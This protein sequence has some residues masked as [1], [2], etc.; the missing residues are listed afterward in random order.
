MNI[1]LVSH[2]FSVTGA[3]NSLLRQA[4][5]FR[6][7]GHN[8]DVWALDSGD[9]KARYIEAGFNPVIVKNS[10]EA[11]KELYDTTNKKYDFVLCNTIIA[12]KAVEVLQQQKIPMV[13]FIR[14]TKLVDDEMLD[15][16]EF[17]NVLNNFYNIYTVS[18]YAANV[19]KKYNK[20]VK[21]I[22]NAV[23]D[24]FYKFKKTDNKIIFGYIGSIMPVKGNDVLLHAFNKFVT[25]HPNIELRI[26]G[27]IYTEWAEKLK[28][29]D[30]KNVKWLG[31][32]QGDAKQSFFDDIDVLVVPSLDE[33]S[34]LTVI[35]GAMY[36]KPIITTDKTGANYLVKNGKSGF[37]VQ[38]G[39]VDDLYNHM[40]IMLNSDLVSMQKESRKMYIN[41][42]T[43][44]KEKKAVLKMLKDN[45]KNFPVIKPI[46]LCRQ[47][48][49]QWYKNIT[50][51]DLN[52]DNPQTFNEKI[53]W[54]KLYDS[55]PIKTKL[56][57]KFLVRKWVTRKIGKKY[58]IP[59]LGA[60]NYFDE[61]DFDKL[62]NQFVIK[63]NH[64]AGYN[65]VVKDKSQLDLKDAR[66][67]IDS[68]MSEDFA[69]K[70]GC[71]LHYH[72]IK[73]KIIIEQLIENKSC[74]DLNDYKFYCFGGKVKYIQVISE[75]TL[76]SHKVC[77]YDT[78]WK[79]QSWWDNDYYEG[80]IKKP[81]NLS[82]ML[83]LASKLSK[84][85]NFVRVDLYYL[86][87][88]EIYFGEMTFTPNSGTMI[89][90]PECIN[91][92]F[93]DLF[94]LPKHE[95]DIET[96]KYRLARRDMKYNISIPVIK[97]SKH[98]NKIKLNVFG[99]QVFKLKNTAKDYI[100]YLFGLQVYKQRMSCGYAKINVCGIRILKYKL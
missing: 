95:Y 38:A 49:S 92:Y 29:L 82:K 91:S 3:P 5:Y 51:R 48:L 37:I 57:D 79:K 32:I 62:P 16:P 17:A 7:A 21:I 50:G 11:I 60:Y 100:I 40:K 9:L 63:C 27:G 58:L 30:V 69:F 81:K 80:N 19:I 77:F 41:Y 45:R 73:H 33:P 20:N 31:E 2:D 42:G 75:R 23:A 15:N 8:V 36:G 54:S 25:E 66:Q 99:T 89:W 72:N 90:N 70:N 96:G 64:G 68:W 43:I 56:A 22:N 65:I 84:G 39:N 14:E 13:W 85:F 26:A 18:K 93:G 94:K 28:K 67:K 6:D 74:S 52:L 34:G 4:C 98:D 76:T 10:Y 83:K 46:N 71:E 53:Q 12:Y 97:Y 86:D 35:E 44:D 24:R 47:E 1:L 87:T 59:L 61:I 88:D 55:T 78:K